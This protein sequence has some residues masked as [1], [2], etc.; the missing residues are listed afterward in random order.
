ME[1]EARRYARR[2]VLLHLLLLVVVGLVVLMA[3]R[4][5]YRNARA[6][7]IEQSAHTQ[8]LLTQQTALGI[9]HYY[10]SVTNGLN[11]LQPISPTDAA[12]QTEELATSRPRRGALYRERRH[13][14]VDKFLETGPVGRARTEQTRRIWDNIRDKAS[15]L[16]ITDA[17]ND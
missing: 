2:I 3:A 4:M 10:E 14:E 17:A 13:A 15:L 16:F 12:T 9:Q 8:E 7:A 11:L 1:L 6:V 5:L